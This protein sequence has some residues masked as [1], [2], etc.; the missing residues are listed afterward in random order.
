MPRK[1]CDGTGRGF[2]CPGCGIPLE[3]V[4]TR[5]TPGGIVRV[6]VCPV[7]FH[8]QRTE[9]RSQGTIPSRSGLVAAGSTSGGS[10]A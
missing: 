10:P 2:G 5:A 7:C 9:E 3:V 8:L 1:K 6:R 4:F